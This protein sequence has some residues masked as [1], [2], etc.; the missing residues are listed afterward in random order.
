M[1]KR[2][3]KNKHPTLLTLFI[4]LGGIMYWVDLYFTVYDGDYV[5]HEIW[6]GSRKAKTLRGAR[7]IANKW[8]KQGAT[9]YAE[10]VTMELELVERIG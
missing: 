2:S 10:I 7:R 5:S 9:N 3:N 4:S 8:I 1:R 6:V